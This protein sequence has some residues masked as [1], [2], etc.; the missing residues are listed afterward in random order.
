M[1]ALTGKLMRIELNAF[2]Y[3][4]L[5]CSFVLFGIV[6]VTLKVFKEEEDG[7]GA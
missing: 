3:T 6:I 7:E 2:H 1:S 4:L 5:G